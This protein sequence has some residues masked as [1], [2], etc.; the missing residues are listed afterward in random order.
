[1]FFHTPDLDIEKLIIAS[2]VL[3]RI[4][5]FVKL[6]LRIRHNLAQDAQEIRIRNSTVMGLVH[7]ISQHLKHNTPLSAA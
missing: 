3:C 5:G 6:W 2:C 7:K 1:M 4:P